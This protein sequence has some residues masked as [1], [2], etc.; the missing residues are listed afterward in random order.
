MGVAASG[1][2]SGS[3]EGSLTVG[4]NSPFK[5]DHRPVS[6]R[7]LTVG[8]FGCEAETVMGAGIGGRIGVT[9][10]TSVAGRFSR[11]LPGS[12]ASGGVGIR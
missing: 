1:C 11:V 6:A 7:S 9:A 3:G 5:R 8:A 10:A 4:E 12:I 2:G